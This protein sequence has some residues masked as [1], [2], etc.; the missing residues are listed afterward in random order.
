MHRGYTKRWRKRWDKGYHQDL[1]LWALMDYFID[2]ANYKDGKAFINGKM[3]PV[4]RGQHIFGRNQLAAFFNVNS[5][6][7][8]RKLKILKNMDFL[9][10]KSN[11]RYSIATVI[12]YDTYQPDEFLANSKPNSPPNN[13]RTAN[14]QQANTPKESKEG[15]KVNKKEFSQAGPF[16]KNIFEHGS[17]LKIK[18]GLNEVANKLKDENIFK[19]SHAFKNKMAKEGKNERAILHSLCRCYIKGKDK[20]FKNNSLAWAYCTKIMEVENGNYNERE[21]TKNS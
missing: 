2:H 5:S 6:L 19:N 9:N 1:L 3:I 13:S 10:I 21:N 7:V 14:E 18:E 12:N 20:P 17:S 8:Y 4:K 16:S 15:N 11:N